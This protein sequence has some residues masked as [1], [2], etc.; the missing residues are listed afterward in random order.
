MKR[1]FITLTLAITLLSSAICQEREPRNLLQNSTTLEELRS[2]LKYN[3]EW[4]DYPAYSDREGWKER[5]TP[6]MREIVIKE[7]EAA[8][9]YEWRPD[10]AT[11]YL[12]YK[13]TGEILTG[14]ENHLALQKLTIAELVEG[15]G[16]F[17]DAIINGVW[18]LCST[19]W[20]HSAHLIYQKDQSGLPDRK[21]PTVELVVADIGAQMAWN[22]YLLGEE[23]DKVSPLINERI[24]E[25]VYRQLLDPYFV[26]DDYWWMGFNPG[27]K[28]NNW[29]VWINYNVLQSLMLMERDHEVIASGVWK[30]MRSTDSFIN[31][32]K[33][34]GA[35]EEGSTYWGHAGANF[36]KCLDMFERITGGKVNL[37]K[38]E[39]VQNIGKY[40]YRAHIAD[41]YF[42]NFADASAVGSIKSAVAYQYG[43]CIDD[44]VMMRFAASFMKP[45]T[46][47]SGFLATALD[48]VLM[49]KEL[50]QIEKGSVSIKSYWWSGTEVCIARDNAESKEGFFFA[51]KGGNNDESHNHNDIGTFILYYNS[52][53][54]LIDVGVGEYTKQTFSAERYK[55]WSMQSGFHNLPK[56]NGVDQMNG[57]EYRAKDVNFVDKESLV[58]F[59]LDISSAYPKTANVKSWDRS[60]T[61]RR[62]ENFTISDK[63]RLSKVTGEN[64]INFMTYCEV[65][66]VKLGEIQLKGDGFTLLLKYNHK[67]VTPIIEPIVLTDSKLKKTWPKALLSRII[68]KIDNID[69]IGENSF[70]I[71]EVK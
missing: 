67:R 20:I 6:Q 15:K 59:S 35:C 19:D 14:R 56:I 29:T 60:Y 8:L 34:D 24:K 26:R 10:L 32:Y 53:P 12:A 51:A 69:L 57:K 50:S 2:L 33:D 62:G 39:L 55:I 68:F 65:S 38:D 43:K 27:Q 58:K 17:L 22:Y 23:F 36:L 31:S 61:L 25:E 9:S 52:K 64:T 13:R 46:P 44:P 18:F 49:S 66:C 41:R 63:W 11:D 47:P 3:Q 42:V 30:I 5:V 1:I 70:E 28:V 45:N 21:E 37:F 40:L 16:R 4:V 71:I 7:G 48:E 54:A